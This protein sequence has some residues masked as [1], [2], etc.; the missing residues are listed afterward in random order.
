ML[1]VIA[2]GL[3]A[4]SDDD[5]DDIHILESRVDSRVMIHVR[6]V[7]MHAIK[8]LRPFAMVQHRTRVPT[9]GCR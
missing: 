2:T 5:N 4:N 7:I 1:P 6:L 3:L 9:A 8:C